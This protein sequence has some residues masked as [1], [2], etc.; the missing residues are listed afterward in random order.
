MLRRTTVPATRETTAPG[1]L[2]SAI[3]ER[4]AGIFDAIRSNQDRNHRFTRSVIEST[5]QSNRDW[6]EVG[7]RWVSNPTDVTGIYDA[8]SD[9]IGNGQARTL[10]LSREWLEDVVETQRESRDLLRRGLG[11]AREAVEQTAARVPQFLR[12]NRLVPDGNKVSPNK[13]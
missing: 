3:L 13:A 11:D 5:R 1:R 6:I 7:R 9:A 12:R 2:T 8:V 4:Q 10:A